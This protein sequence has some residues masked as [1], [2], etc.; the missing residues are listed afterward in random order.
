MTFNAPV[1][2]TSPFDQEFYMLRGLLVTPPGA[3]SGGQ[4]TTAA[5]DDTVLLQA[6]VYNYSHLD[7]NDPSLAQPAAKVRVRFYGQL[8]RSEAGD[9]PVGASFLIGE[10]ELAPL[11]GFASDT[12]PGNLPNWTVAVQEFSPQNFAPAQN[13][14]VYVRFW[15][16]VWM[17]D[18][19]GNLVAEMPG[20]GLQANPRLGTINTM[21]DVQIEPYSNN[22]GSL[23]QIFY[24]E[25]ANAPGTVGT[26]TAAT[27]TA[28]TGTA[29][30]GAP[31]VVAAPAAGAAAALSLTLETLQI[32]PPAAP[33][34][35]AGLRGK[36]QLS[37]TIRNGPGAGP[38][39]L[40]YYDGD[41]EAGGRAFDWEMIPHLKPGA[42]FVNRVTYTPQ[43]CGARALY[44]VAQLGSEEIT[45][46]TGVDNVPCTLI[47]PVIRK[48]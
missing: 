31:R 40:V 7:M 5:V 23:K 42:Q 6:R 16:V 14:D 8:F 34:T 3:P 43:A 29:G 30:I 12:T 19:G 1:T 35:A 37:A 36:H 38:L 28:A 17:E 26:G 21:G 20:H 15:V 25:P 2:S 41:P 4:I 46:K 10:Q 27:G 11:P 24:V 9:Y 22:V 32:V 33:P 48:Q 45:A 47:L 39:I 44:V 13:G 18:A